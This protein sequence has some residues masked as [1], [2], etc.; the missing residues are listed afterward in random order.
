MFRHSLEIALKIRN[1]ISS[2]VKLSSMV[3]QEGL[4]IGSLLD[5][6]IESLDLS[7]EATESIEHDILVKRINVVGWDD[8]TH[9]KSDFNNIYVLLRI[10]LTIQGV[11]VDEHIDNKLKKFLDL[12][13]DGVGAEDL[14]I[15]FHQNLGIN[16][17]EKL[18]IVDEYLEK[19]IEKIEQLNLIT[20]QVNFD[21]LVDYFDI[22]Q[23]AYNTDLGA[24]SREE[25]LIAVLE[26][27]QLT[28]QDL[29]RPL[30]AIMYILAFNKSLPDA[31]YRPLRFKLRDSL[32]EVSYVRTNGSQ[33]ARFGDGVAGSKE[34]TIKNLTNGNTI[35]FGELV[36]QLIACHGLYEDNVS[37]QLAPQSIMEVF[38]CLFPAPKAQYR[39]K[40]PL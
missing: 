3:I 11:R 27:E 22:N 6:F 17:Y 8:V 7:I 9:E 20:G 2:G 16:L 23:Q 15:F 38:D 34:Y 26:K 25:S 18:Q 39:P 35:K 31:S 29:A 5:P 12:S 40:P 33:N 36:P 13:D 28:H 37:Y 1:K 14:V 4:P 32:F 21:F 24:I 10:M 19:I 30:L